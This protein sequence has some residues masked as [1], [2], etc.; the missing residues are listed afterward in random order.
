MNGG[1][2]HLVHSGKANYGSS[3]QINLYVYTK[4]VYQ[5]IANNYTRVGLGMYVQTPGS[6]YT[7]AWSD[8]GGSYIGVSGVGSNSFNCGVSYKGGKIWLVTNQEF[9]VYHNSDG[10]RWIDVIW[11]WDVNSTWG[12][13]VR[14][15]GS[16]GMSLPPIPRTSKVSCTDFNIGSTAIVN[17]ERSSSS[18]THTLVWSFGNASGTIADRT[19][20]TSVGW[21]TPT[22]LFAQIPNDTKGW[23]TVTCYT[24]SGDTLIGTSSCTFNAF[25]VNSNPNVEV[26]IVDTNSIT[27]N[28]TGDE[29][30]LVKYFSNAK[31]KVTASA[32]NYSSIK[33]YSVKCDDGKS[34]NNSEVTMNKVE[35]GNFT[36]VVTDSRG[37][38]TTKTIKKTMIDYIKLALTD[39]KVKRESSTSSKV[40]LTYTGQY[41]SGS[42]G[43]LLNTLLVRYRTRL[44]NGTWGNYQTLEPTINGSNISQSNVLIG[45][46]FSY[47]NSYE[48][49]IIASDKLISDS[50]TKVTKEIKMGEGLFEIR[51]NLFGIHGTFETDTKPLNEVNIN[52]CISRTFFATC[53]NC[54]NTPNNITFGYLLNISRNGTDERELYNKQFFFDGTSNDIYVRTM[55]NAT[56]LSWIKV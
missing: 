26:S 38:S 54:S 7:I 33:S 13:F 31:I 36:I 48:F 14:P 8:F 3:F 50:E 47:H 6:S 42:F 51:K 19:G 29:N 43:S 34:S 30:K 40:Y 25:V 20:Q 15:S 4:N 16:F 53:L 5:D 24:Y 9:N 32:L 17:I 12:Q 41:F 2:A 39:V 44:K 56:W 1:T 45:S 46:N 22:S 21:N 18:F 28:L 49:E 37:F 10:T 27:K 23:G 55:N 52:N 35:S 11:K